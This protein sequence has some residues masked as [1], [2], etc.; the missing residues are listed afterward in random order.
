MARSKIYMVSEGRN[1][2][3]YEMLF[4][5][6][7]LSIIFLGLQGLYPLSREKSLCFVGI[8]NI[9]MLI[10]SASNYQWELFGITALM[11][12]AQL[13]RLKI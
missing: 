2:M 4:F 11:M 12:I 9:N 6:F 8:G 13:T 3:I 7:S 1:I 10:Y 5:A